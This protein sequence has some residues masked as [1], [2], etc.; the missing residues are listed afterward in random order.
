MRRREFVSLLLGGVACWPL[1]VRA[2]RVTKPVI[3]FINGAS[4]KPY[5]PNVSGFLQGL[6]EAGYSVGQNVLV[7]YRWA[8]G[9]YDRLPEMAAELVRLGVTVIVANTPAAPVAKAATAT[10]PIVFMTGD[11]PVTSGLVVSLNRP[12][13]N[14]TGIGITGPA[15]LGKQ[16]EVLHQAV[17]N[18]TSIVFLVNPNNPN[19][20]PSVRGAR[21]AAHALGRQILVVDAASEAE[22]DKAFADLKGVDGVV[23]APDAFFIA[24]REQ[25]VTLAAREALPAI[26]PFREFTAIGGLMSYGASLSDQYRLAGVYAGKILH[27]SKPSELPV[28]QPT[29]YD[30]AI[31][32]NTTRKLGLQLPPSLLAL[33]DEVVE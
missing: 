14:V 4:P 23:I 31:N 29:K 24:R 1:A 33:A 6:E 21:E 27:G 13:G 15:L 19:S 30:L 26:Y 10:I 16:L 28:M 7:E 22:I 18:K 25:L 3:G 5:A 2:Q 11:D 8:E 20:E 9:H 32:L 12:E 17:P